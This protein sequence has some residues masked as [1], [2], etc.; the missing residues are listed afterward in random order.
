M[1][2]L[3]SDGILCA[4]DYLARYFDYDEMLLDFYN[5]HFHLPTF[6]MLIHRVSKDTLINNDGNFLLDLCKS[7]NLFILN[8]RCGR[9]K[10][11]GSLTFKDLSTIDYSLSSFD[12]LKYIANFSVYPVDTLFSDGHALLETQFKFNTKCIS[13]KPRQQQKPTNEFCNYKWQ[14]SKKADFKVNIDHVKV[15]EIHKQLIQNL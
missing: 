14:E 10:G 15:E 9:D 11:I 2:E 8:G 7:C 1:P 5:K 12:G 6:D 13:E 4:D 3:D